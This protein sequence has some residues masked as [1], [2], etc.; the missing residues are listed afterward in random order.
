MQRVVIRA[1]V[2]CE[3]LKRSKVLGERTKGSTVGRGCAR[4]VCDSS[5]VRVVHV[6]ARVRVRGFC[7]SDSVEGEVDW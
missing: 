5:G 6:R 2:L 1:C 7:A 3:G 4:I